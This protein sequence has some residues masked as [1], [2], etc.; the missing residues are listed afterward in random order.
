MT[1]QLAPTTQAPAAFAPAGTWDVDPAHSN[2]EFV[3]RHMFTS[4]R[5]RFGEFSGV[6]EVGATPE[7]SKLEGTIAAASIDT[8]LP[9][10]DAHLRSPDFLDAENHPSLSFRSTSAR[11][12]SGGRL[13]VDG[14]LTIRGVTRPVTLEVEFLGS[15]TDPWSGERAGFSARTEIDREDFGLTWN[16]PLAAGGVLVG[17]RVKIELE[18]E[19]VRRQG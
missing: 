3:V 9:D 10:R 16:L 14:E 1:Q 7:Q 15:A 17:R 6:L 4:M 12:S 18:V 19:A 5:G 13:E 8:R 2:V 11:S